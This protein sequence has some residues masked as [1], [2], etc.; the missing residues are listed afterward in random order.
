MDKS[1][2][3]I[4]D[5][6]IALTSIKANKVYPQHLRCIK[7]H[8]AEHD[9]DLVFR[10]NNFALAALTIAQLYRCRRQVEL[11]FHARIICFS[12]Y[13]LRGCQALVQVNQA[14]SSDQAVLRHLRERGQNT[15]MNRHFDLRPSRYCEET[16]Q[17]RVFT[18]HNMTDIEPDTFR[19][20][21]T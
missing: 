17:N 8:D 3:L 5:Q 13:I 4:Y 1:T 7:I 12:R 14:A 9:R 2:G 20:N 10:T 19:K 16:P 15:N 21:S 18:L 6:T 11:F